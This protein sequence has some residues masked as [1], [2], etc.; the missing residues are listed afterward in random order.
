MAAAQSDKSEIPRTQARPENTAESSCL[1]IARKIVAASRSRKQLKSIYESIPDGASLEKTTDSALT[2]KVPDQDDTVL[3]KS[4][5]ARFAIQ[6]Q[7]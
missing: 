5:V 3:Q 4:E 1:Q 7:L 2:I 6:A